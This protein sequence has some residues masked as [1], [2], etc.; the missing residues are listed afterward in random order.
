MLPVDTST[1]GHGRSVEGGKK[2]SG[3][4]VL[5]VLQSGD[6]EMEPL[7]DSLSPSSKSPTPD[8]QFDMGEEEQDGGLG[9]NAPPVE[10]GGEVVSPARFTFSAPMD[11]IV[12]RSYQFSIA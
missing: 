11:N 10:I 12:V 6:G 8:P 2:E 5:S 3:C 7:E 1:F 4:D 9:N